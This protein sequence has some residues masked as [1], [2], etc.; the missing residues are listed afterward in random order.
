MFAIVVGVKK[1][2]GARTNCCR[3]EAGVW[4]KDKGNS[5]APTVWQRKYSEDECG[6]EGEDGAIGEVTHLE[7]R[8][9]EGMAL[10]VAVYTSAVGGG[11]AE[12]AVC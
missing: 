7:R 4:G 8:R 9:I 5:I 11:E 3:G 1:T 10:R 12:D 6:G 2:K